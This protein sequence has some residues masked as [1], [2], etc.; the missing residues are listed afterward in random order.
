M[1]GHKNALELTGSMQGHPTL[2]GVFNQLIEDFGF[3]GRETDQ[4][5]KQYYD[6]LIAPQFAAIKENETV[7]D[8]VARTVAEIDRAFVHIEAQCE[9][10]QHESLSKLKSA[11]LDYLWARCD[12]QAS[13]FIVQKADWARALFLD[14]APEYRWVLADLALKQRFML[15]KYPIDE[16]EADLLDPLET[17]TTNSR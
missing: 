10:R 7:D 17:E 8:A 15:A 14:L 4:F 5:E 1:M 3:E 13:V 12:F 9:R 16:Q 2:R 6:L 11:F